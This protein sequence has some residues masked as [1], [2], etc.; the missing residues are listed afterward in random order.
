MRARRHSKMLGEVVAGVRS[1]GW[2][3]AFIDT[4]TS[5]MFGGRCNK[6]YG[7]KIAQQTYAPGL[8]CHWCSRTCAWR[9]AEAESAGVPMPSVGVVRDGDHGN[10]ARY[11]ELD[12]TALG[13]VRG[14][15]KRDS[16]RCTQ[17]LPIE[18]DF[19]PKVSRRMHSKERTDHGSSSRIAQM[20][21]ERTEITGTSLKCRPSP[22]AL[23]PSA[24]DVGWYRRS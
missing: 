19:A 5:T 18:L 13:L 7:D 12:W 23:G 21:M 2:T 11:G 20:N 8:S 4:M 17:S 14:G 24:G 16:T 6:I 22:S 10:R 3:P 15:R 9:F 1:A